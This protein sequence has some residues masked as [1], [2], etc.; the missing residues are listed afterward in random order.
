[1]T[2]IFSQPGA[3]AQPITPQERID[4]IAATSAEQRVQALRYLA[5]YDP[6]TLDAILDAVEPFDENEDPEAGEDAEPFCV[7]CAE[8]LGI[9]LRFGPDWKHYRDRG[10]DVAAGRFEV[11]TADHEPVLAW[12]A[13][14]LSELLR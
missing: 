1:M 6:R 7:A 8:S 14:D 10:E 11:F 5:G 3:G 2:R 4:R 12:R 13:V 9:F